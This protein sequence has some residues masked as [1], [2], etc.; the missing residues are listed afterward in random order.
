MYFCIH[1]FIHTVYIYIQ[2]YVCIYI[3]ISF[4]VDLAISSRFRK[5]RK[6]LTYWSYR[7][8]S[9]TT[10][11]LTWWG[12][13][14]WRPHC[15]H[16]NFW[17]H[18]EYSNHPDLLGFYQSFQPYLAMV[19]SFQS[20]PAGPLGES[21]ICQQPSTPNCPSKKRIQPHSFKTQNLI[22]TTPKQKIL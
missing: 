8:N 10:E 12:V 1:I 17:K 14:K 2:T 11:I 21:Y 16:Q 9:E 20:N 5:D 6:C 18:V 7:H 22:K 4:L 15:K 13:K 19:R 3:Y